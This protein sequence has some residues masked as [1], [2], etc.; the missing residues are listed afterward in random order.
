M[1]TS[2]TSWPSTVSSQE[3]LPV[4]T[5]R[6]LFDELVKLAEQAPVEESK[7]GG[8]GKALRAMGVGA[9]GLG[10]GYGLSELAVRKLPFFNMPPSSLAPDA[11][12]KLMANRAAAR[13]IILPI[14]TGAA[15]MLADRYRQHMN[16][17][18]RQVRGYN[19]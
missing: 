11:A 8:L 5:K 7:K 10:V 2:T 18:Y 1:K 13:K 16:E 12:Q 15:V 9:A 4:D 17:Q 14:L 6:A 3:A 19:G